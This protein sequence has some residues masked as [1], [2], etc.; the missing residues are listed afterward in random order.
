MKK[1]K[2]TEEEA[3][4]ELRSLID[5]E[6]NITKLAKHFAVSVAFMSM[7]L[8]GRK[9]ITNPMLSEIGVQRCVEYYR[10]VDR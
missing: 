3:L 8:K 6:T 10:I 2:I 9:K 5:Y 1:V 4:H 7:V